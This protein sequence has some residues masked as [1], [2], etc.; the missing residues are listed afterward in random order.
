MRILGSIFIGLAPF[1]F[2]V[3]KYSL[4]MLRK[5]AF[6]EI[7]TVLQEVINQINYTNKELYK[8]LECYNAPYFK[9]ES[10]IRVNENYMK[11]M[12]VN[13]K[14]TAL[15]NEFLLALQKGDREYLSSRSKQ[16]LNLITELK[17]EAETE[18]KQKGKVTLAVYGGIGLMAFLV[19]V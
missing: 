19:L 15:I 10:P 18:L 6:G 17:T 9:L 11:T 7:L 14:E 8:I 4:L 5:K 13:L 2:G 3:K 12:G 16:G 1:V